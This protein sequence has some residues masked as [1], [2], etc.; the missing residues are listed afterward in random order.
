MKFQFSGKNRKIEAHPK[1]AKN[2]QNPCS[3][4]RASYGFLTLKMLFLGPEASFG[5]F[6]QF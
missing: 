1:I 3:K 6:G 4:I 5:H 2:D